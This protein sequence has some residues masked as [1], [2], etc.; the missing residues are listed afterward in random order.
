MKYFKSFILIFFKDTNRCSRI[1]ALKGNYNS[2]G[3]KIPNNRNH[4]KRVKK[5]MLSFRV[6]FT[7]SIVYSFY[8]TSLVTT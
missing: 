7:H 8:E 5:V 6:Y 1:T 3:T 2:S 4:C